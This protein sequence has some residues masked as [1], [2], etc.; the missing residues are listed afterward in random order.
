MNNRENEITATQIFTTVI[1]YRTQSPIM[2]KKHSIILLLTAIFSSG[3]IYATAQVKDYLSIPGSI[4]FENINYDLSWS[5]HPAANYFKHEYLPKGA[6][7]EKYKQMLLVEFVEGDITPK[8][9]VGAKLVELAELKKTNPIVNF[10]VRANKQLGEYILDFLVSQNTP[11][12]Q[13]VNIIERNVYR[14]KKITDAAG[15]T[16]VLLFGVSTRAYGDDIDQFFAFLKTNRVDMLRS[17][18]GYTIPVIKIAE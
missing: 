4:S 12:G 18:S 6:D 3:S 8:D 5:S 11:D 16:G 1:C 7:A 13:H 15:R 2:R 14:Y 10:D 17:V 9:V